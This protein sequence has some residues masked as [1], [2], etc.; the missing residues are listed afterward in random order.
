MKDYSLTSLLKRS[1]KIRPEQLA[2]VLFLAGIFVLPFQFFT[3]VWQPAIHFSGQANQFTN[4]SIYLTDILVV[5][6]ALFFF[7]FK[8][9]IEYGDKI[10]ACVLVALTILVMA[11]NTVFPVG[12]LIFR[13]LFFW[14]L[15]LLLKNEVTTYEKLTKTILISA[16]IQ[17]LI[18][19]AQF[20]KQS[21]I[22]I[23]GEPDL[24]SAEIAKIDI[25]DAKKIRGYGTMS[26]PNILGGFLVLAT[27]LGIRLK[28]WLPLVAICLAGLIFTFSRSALLALAITGLFFAFFNFKKILV[29]KQ[30][31]L[32]I[33][34]IIAILAG[35]TAFKSH[36][37]STYELEERLNQLSPTIDMIIKNPLGV[38]WQNFTNE[39]QAYTEDKLMPWEYQPIHNVY[40]LV[41]AEWG[42][43]GIIFVLLLLFFTFRKNEF[44]YAILSFAIIALFDH[45]L[46]TLYAGEVMTITLLGMKKS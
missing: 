20:I 15:Y 44:K 34:A 24:S 45:Y 10:T 36:I 43:A 17:A 9:K 40:L 14:I 11:T 38:G 7:P 29:G 19:T 21:S 2:E 16:S 26:H 1:K 4:A 5:L 33:V 6:S 22:G 13:L 46:C 32:I 18:A 28:K 41:T 31:Y 3:I 8:K 12:W 37:F 30:K 25:G 39:I 23:I 27:I 42:I 35:G